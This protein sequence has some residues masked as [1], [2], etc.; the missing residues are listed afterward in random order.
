MPE[1]ISAKNVL[2]LGSGTGVLGLSMI[3]YKPARVT[4][5]DLPEYLSLLV[6]NIKMNSALISKY[7][8]DKPDAITGAAL[9]WG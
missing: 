1:F 2:E 6:D 9:T 3:P 7:Y 4:M 8:P 5:T